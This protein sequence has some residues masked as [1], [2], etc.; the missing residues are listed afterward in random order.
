MAYK[1]KSNDR[2][3]D[4]VK[5]SDNS[6]SE[7]HKMGAYEVVNKIDNFLKTYQKDDKITEA[8]R[9][10]LRHYY[11]MRAV[12]NKYGH[13]IGKIGGI[14]HEG[15]DLLFPTESKIQS[16]IDIHN[17]KVASMHIRMKFGKDISN[18]M[19]LEEIKEPLKYLKIPPPWQET[20][21]QYK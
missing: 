14:V 7:M 20:A 17:N 4:M 21:V 19:T 1:P 15:F 3:F 18:D 2:V 10:A 6:L 8:E 11:G 5:Y 16:D 12:I 13:E 9:A